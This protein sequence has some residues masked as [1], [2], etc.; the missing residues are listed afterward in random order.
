[1]VA[2]ILTP[3]HPIIPVTNRKA[4]ADD[5]QDDETEW[6]SSRCKLLANSAR[7]QTHLPWIIC[8]IED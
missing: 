2:D 7:K 3:D 1:M 5:Q 4:H 8:C 6:P